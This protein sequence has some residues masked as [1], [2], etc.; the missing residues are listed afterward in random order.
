MTLLTVILFALGL[1]LVAGG[2]DI[3]VRGAARLAVTMGVSP[4]V[5]GLTVVAYGTSMPELAVSLQASVT[6]TPDI[7]VGNV[8]GS[9]IYN[10]LLI[11]GLAAVAAP[12]TVSR[13]LTRLDVPLMIG[14]SVLLMLMSLDG[15][16]S[17]IEGAILFAGCVIYTVGSIRKGRREVRDARL[18]GHDRAPEMPATPFLQRWIQPIALAV[19][20][21][22]LLVLGSAWVKGGA[23]AIAR[24]CGVSELVIALTVVAVGTSLPEVA[25]SVAAALRGEREM[26]VGNAVGSNMFNILLVIGSTSA[27]ASHGLPVAVEALRFDMPVMI[28]IAVACLPIFATGR[29][30]TRVEGAFF[31]LYGTAYT[32]FLVHK[33]RSGQSPTIQDA[34]VLVFMVLL[35]AVTA[36]VIFQK[37]QAARKARCTSHT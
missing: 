11:L 7:A 34:A 12:L 17:R 16:V 1:A 8:I 19:V 33:A 18:L 27:L 35:P 10:I 29:R 5:I 25:T 6:G 14:V 21:L 31:L 26:A 30:I 13:Q 4:L 20:G 37:W 28:A 23:V 36:L 3:F 32:A 9:N 15:R 2:A 22:A 24:W